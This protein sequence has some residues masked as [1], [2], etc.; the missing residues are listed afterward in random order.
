MSTISQD[1]NTRQTFKLDQKIC[2]L[3]PAFLLSN[4]M[5]TSVIIHSGYQ[6]FRLP[7]ESLSLSAMKSCW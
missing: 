7:S 1:E 4:T 3:L 2:T 5:G 6:N